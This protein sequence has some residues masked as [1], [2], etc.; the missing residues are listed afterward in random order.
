[1][2]EADQHL[3]PFRRGFFLL[4]QTAPMC[5][6]ATSAGSRVREKRAVIGGNNRPHKGPEG[7]A[8]THVWESSRFGFCYSLGELIGETA[9]RYI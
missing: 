7:L 8:M 6:P 5:P 3:A 9:T 2:Q 1:V 4:E